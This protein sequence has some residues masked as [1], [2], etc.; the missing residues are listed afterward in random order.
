V[1]VESRARAG[2]ALA[3]SATQRLTSVRAAGAATANDGARKKI[4]GGAN[5]N[6]KMNQKDIAFTMY[7]IHIL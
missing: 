3:A 2:A 5:F 1:R 7:R 6:H 4:I